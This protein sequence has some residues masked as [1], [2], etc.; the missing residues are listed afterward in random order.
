[1]FI[2]TRD[3]DDA[4]LHADPHAYRNAN[5]LC[6]WVRER[7]R[8]LP[9][10]FFVIGNSSTCFSRFLVGPPPPPPRFVVYVVFFARL[11]DWESRFFHRKSLLFERGGFL[12]SFFRTFK[13]SR[14]E[15]RNRKR[16]NSRVSRDDD[17][18]GGIINERE[19][20]FFRL[21]W[22]EFCRR[23]RRTRNAPMW[24]LHWPLPWPFVCY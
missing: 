24:F 17:E 15:T 4:F 5:A 22:G 7:E 13:T 12:L 11:I 10:F 16:K 2:T 8:A 23:R 14:R 1:M 9:S 21:F 6:C 18:E 3:D 20:S 19:P